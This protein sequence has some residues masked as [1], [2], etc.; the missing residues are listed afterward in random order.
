MKRPCLAVRI[1]LIALLLVAAGL[2]LLLLC[3]PTWVFFAALALVLIAV[4]L[5]LFC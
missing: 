1:R 4:G 3:V 2:I 5:K